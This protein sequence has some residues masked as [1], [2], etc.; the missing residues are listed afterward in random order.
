MNTVAKLTIYNFDA[1]YSV[2]SKFH[3]VG[4]LCG[5]QSI[6]LTRVVSQLS[7]LLKSANYDRLNEP[8]TLSITHQQT[9]VAAKLWLSI[10]SS[11]PLRLPSNA[12][13]L[14]AQ[15]IQHPVGDLQQLQLAIGLTATQSQAFELNRDKIHDLFNHKSRQE[16]LS[17]LELK[18]ESLQTQSQQL[19]VEVEQ[20]TGELQQAMIEADAANKAKSDFLANMSHEIRTPMNAI[21]GMSHLVLQTEL[22]GKQRNYIEKVNLS[23]ESLLGIINDILDFSKIEAGKLTLEKIPFQLDSV[24][25]NLGNLISLKAEEKD[26]EFLFDIAPEVP[27][28]LIGDP[29]RLGQVLINL[30][31][32]AVKFTEQGHVVVR[33]R[34]PNSGS[35]TAQLSF[36]VEDSGIGMSAE[37]QAKLFQS[38][39]QADTSTTRKYGGTGLGLSISKRLV[40]MMGGEISVSS[41]QGQGSTFKFNAELAID[42]EQQQRQPILIKP[43][44]L[45]DLRVLIVDDNFIANQILSMM[46]ESFGFEVTSVTSGQRAI[47]AMK[48]AQQ[49]FDLAFVDWRMPG[50]D[51][52][53]T[54]KALKVLGPLP[55]VMLTAAS[56][57]DVKEHAGSPQLLNGV[58]S[59]PVSASSLYDTVMEVFGLEQ[60]HRRQD[61]KTIKCES[62]SA[63]VQKLAGAHLL[64][65]E[66]NAFNQELAIE[67]LTANGITV[68]VAENGVEAIKCIESES[69]DGVLMDCQMPLMD[70]F[71]ATKRIRALNESFAS[72]PIIA[73]TANVM[74]SDRKRVLEAGMN[75]HIGKPIRVEDMFA[76]MAKW[77]VPAAPTGLPKQQLTESDNLADNLVSQLANVSLIDSDIGLIN[78]EQNPKLYRKLLLQFC[79]SQSQ[80]VSQFDDA[81][82][83][84]DFVTCMRLAHTIKGLLATIGANGLVAPAQALEL[85]CEQ[86]QSD[87]EVQLAQFKPSIERLLQQLHQVNVATAP[88][89]KS[90]KQP[91]AHAELEH[92]LI[93]IIECCEQFDSAAPD[94]LEQLEQFQLAHEQ[95]QALRKAYDLLKNYDFEQAQQ[96]LAAMLSPH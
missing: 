32:N 21:I 64:L 2:R 10:G 66:D 86:Q 44:E 25:A 72:M 62:F 24:M 45:D 74:T 55:I 8:V 3:R 69:F 12:N 4:L 38:F 28:S 58:L 78:T 50:L 84:Q 83:Q 57:S 70:G 96:L 49:P 17:E 88:E 31:N 35:D 65:V 30:A 34:C 61:R 27:Q 14:F 90:A 20:R 91:L 89:D 26:L 53:A 22:E 67:F 9:P 7:S 29:L 19:A 60:Q 71:E 59:K 36:S 5:L 82:A 18:N 41:Q 81:F 94:L 85:A 52:V 33:V 87:V 77:I 68:V 15:V 80:F 76:T 11:N 92:R 51:G 42:H 63:N 48:Q 1:I 6:Y 56:L 13:S 47:E 95:R 40:D 75:D 43:A 37:Q 46:L 16:L 54:A 39:S 93:E 79:E 73:M 23:A